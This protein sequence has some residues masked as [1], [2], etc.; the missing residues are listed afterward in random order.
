MSN[1]KTPE[2]DKT[3]VE[4]MKER[5]TPKSYNENNNKAQ[6]KSL[7]EVKPAAAT[8]PKDTAP[9]PEPSKPSFV[10]KLKKPPT[11]KP[12]TNTPPKGPK[13]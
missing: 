13:R 8:P 1:D 3:W 6:G 5:G 10:D 7:Y 4:R 2:N 12:P 9:K 11:Q